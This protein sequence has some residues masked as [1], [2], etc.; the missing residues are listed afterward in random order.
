MAQSPERAIQVALLY[1]AV[2]LVEGYVITPLVQRR[3]VD[4][5]AGLVLV[6]QAVAGLTAGVLGVI[7]ATPLA[8]IVLVVIRRLYV[9]PMEAHSQRTPT[10]PDRVAC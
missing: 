9:E 8:A 4:M 6:A 1:L 7:F 3:A 2:Q 5:P 10:H